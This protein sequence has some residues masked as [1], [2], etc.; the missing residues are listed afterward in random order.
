MTD[1]LELA[2]LVRVRCLLVLVSLFSTSGVSV[3]ALGPAAVQVVPQGET[4]SITETQLAAFQPAGNLPRD[5]RRECALGI[6]GDG[7]FGLILLGKHTERT[8]E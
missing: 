4:A 8:P 5:V 1:L 6:L 2:V 3:A 7:V